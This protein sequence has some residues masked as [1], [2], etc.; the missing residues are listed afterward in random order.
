MRY[1]FISHRSS[2][3]IRCDESRCYLGR[4]EPLCGQVLPP[5]PQ[6][7]PASQRLSGSETE[8]IDTLSLL[9]RGVLLSQESWTEIPSQASVNVAKIG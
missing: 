6:S 9:P 3:K 1:I 2:E 7:F 5:A 8:A 4:E